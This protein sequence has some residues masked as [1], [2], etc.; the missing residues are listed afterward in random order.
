MLA[1]P[2]ETATLPPG[3]RSR[4]VRGVNGLCGA[5]VSRGKGIES[6]ALRISARTLTSPRLGHQL[7]R[8][9]GYALGNRFKAFLAG[10]GVTAVL[11]SS[12]AAG[13][14]VS[15]F[16]AGVVT[17]FARRSSC[18]GSAF[19]AHGVPG[20]RATRLPAYRSRS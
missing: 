9:L 5:S 2:L 8:T 12:T 1:T 7:R 14:M 3:I 16:A 4:F 10:L 11:R 17:G 20:L 19:E 18:H 13:L 6:R 15:S